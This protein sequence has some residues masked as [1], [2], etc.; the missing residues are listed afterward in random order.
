[1]KYL[2]ESK[3]IETFWYLIEITNLK[4]VEWKYI[5]YIYDK[6][7]LDKNLNMI[8]SFKPICYCDIE[9]IEY[10]EISW[11]RYYKE[12]VVNW[13]FNYLLKTHNDIK[14]NIL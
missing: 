11:I 13:I 3:T 14:N 8:S 1:M 2:Q 9:E 7:K 5:F 6:I 4:N 10:I 12:D